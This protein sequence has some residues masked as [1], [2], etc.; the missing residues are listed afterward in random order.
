MEGG[1]HAPHNRGESVQSAH[2]DGVAVVVG[3]EYTVRNTRTGFERRVR[4]TVITHHPPHTF[5]GHECTEYWNVYFKV[6]KKK[7]RVWA[8]NVA[9]ETFPNRIR[10]ISPIRVKRRGERKGNGVFEE[11]HLR[12]WIKG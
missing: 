11:D 10:K 1:W 4:I 12:G 5:Y 2:I 8:K 9:W 7:E 6:W 3:G